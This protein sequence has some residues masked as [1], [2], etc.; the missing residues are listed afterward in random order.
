VARK[1]IEDEEIALFLPFDLTFAVRKALSYIRPSVLI[2]AETELWPNLITETDRRKIPIVLINGR[3]SERSFHGYSDVKWMISTTLKK[4]SLL[5]M[6]T[7][8]DAERAAKLGADTHSVKVT[9]NIKF[10]SATV[11]TPS[12]EDISAMRLVLSL[13]EED[14][15]LVA[16]S[17]HPGEEEA[18]VDVYRRLVSEF[19]HLRLLIAP[20]H[21]ERTADVEGIIKRQGLTPVKISQLLEPI[22][23]KLS[24]INPVIFVLDTIGKLKNFYAIADVV[25]VG[26]SL[27]KKGGQNMIEPAAFAKPVL[28]GPHTAN[29]RDVARAFLKEG[30]AIMVKDNNSLQDEISRLIK[31]PALCKGYGNKGRAIIEENRGASELTLNSL[32][33]FLR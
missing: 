33:P 24:T 30:A 20:R 1:I 26:G 14:R 31:D 21:V 17:T 2:I 22:N 10:D 27:V 18:L 16:G 25:F 7:K 5:L 32:E 19:K 9:G 6:R 12:E 4:M 3:I 13:Q 28:F 11:S 15:L 29:F 8:V 23:H